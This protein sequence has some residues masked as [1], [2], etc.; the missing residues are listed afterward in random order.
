MESRRR[1]FA[2]ELETAISNCRVE[3]YRGRGVWGACGGLFEALSRK[4]ECRGGTVVAGFLGR[5][6]HRVWNLEVDGG[7][8]EFGKT[9]GVPIPLRFIAARARQAGG[10]GGVSLGGDRVCIRATGFESIAMA[11]GGP[12]PQ[13]ADAEVLDQLCKEWGSERAGFAEMAIV[14]GGRRVASDVSERAIEGR[15]RRSAGA[16]PVSR[17]DVGE[18]REV[19]FQRIAGDTRPDWA[20]MRRS[21]RAASGSRGDE[22]KYPWTK[23]AAKCAEVI[24]LGRFFNALRNDLAIQLASESKN[25][26]DNIVGGS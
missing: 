5:S 14:C 22:R 19:V 3:G 26:I 21:S 9:G 23:L 15:E 10:I 12:G 16:V 25:E 24:E 20:C 4:F 6:T 13:R 17:S 2:A 18:V 11:A 8:E 1:Q 7:A